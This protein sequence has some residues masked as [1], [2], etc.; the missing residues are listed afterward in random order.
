[1]AAVSWKGLSLGPSWK[2]ELVPTVLVS[3]PSG[4]GVVRL[5]DGLMLVASEVCQGGGTYLREADPFH[6]EKAGDEN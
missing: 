5:D 2:N 3:V 1:M 6:P 4:A